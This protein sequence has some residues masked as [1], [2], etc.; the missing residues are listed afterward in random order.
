MVYV[1]CVELRQELKF[2]WVKVLRPTRH[3]IG[4]FGDVLPKQSLGIVLSR[5]EPLLPYRHNADNTKL[6]QHSEKLW[7]PVVHVRKSDGLSIS[8]CIWGKT[9]SYTNKKI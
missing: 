8:I 9:K 3:K 7:L 2:D 6:V 5:T 1:M 4:H